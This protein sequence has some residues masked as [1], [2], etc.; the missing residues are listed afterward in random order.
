MPHSNR[1]NQPFIL[2]NILDREEYIS[3]E[4]IL[5][6]TAEI[7]RD[8]NEIKSLRS[9]IIE[10]K[11][12]VKKERLNP[13]QHIIK[14]FILNVNFWIGFLFLAFLKCF[15]RWSIEKL[16]EHY[17]FSYDNLFNGIRERVNKIRI[18]F[19]KK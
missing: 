14:T 16:Y 4:D 7:K 9:E 5:E 12:Q 8:L 15:T 10:I 19:F 18:Y 1:Y 17:G 6:E 3:I 2:E 13:H 11:K